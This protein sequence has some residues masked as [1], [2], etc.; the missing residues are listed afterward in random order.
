M[1]TR[2][3]LATTSVQLRPLAVDQLVVKSVLSPLKLIVI[4]GSPQGVQSQHGA[5]Q[6]VGS[7]PTR[8]I[9]GALATKTSVLQLSNFLRRDDQ[10]VVVGVVVVTVFFDNDGKLLQ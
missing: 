9:S 5:T 8:Q 4:V 1:D 7:S 10:R 6:K 3:R 2:R